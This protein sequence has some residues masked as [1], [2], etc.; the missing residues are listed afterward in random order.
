[1][2]ATK[3]GPV[4]RSGTRRQARSLAETAVAATPNTR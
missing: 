1:M 2:P 4:T 3:A